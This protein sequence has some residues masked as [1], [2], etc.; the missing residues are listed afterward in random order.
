[1]WSYRKIGVFMKMIGDE[2]MQE[3]CMIEKKERG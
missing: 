1:M 3:R 2:T